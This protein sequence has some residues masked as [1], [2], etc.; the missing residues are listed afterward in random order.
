VAVPLVPVPP[1][2]AK[3]VRK[4]LERLRNERGKG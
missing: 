1:L 3:E 4:T 2:T